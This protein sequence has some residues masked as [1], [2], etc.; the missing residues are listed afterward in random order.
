MATLGAV[1]GVPHYPFHYRQV[2]APSSQWSSETRAMVER[3]EMMREKLAASRP[4]ALVVIGS[5]H[6][7]QFFMDN[8][9]QFLLGKMAHFDGIFYNEIREFGMAP[10]TVPGDEQ[11]AG[12]LL[13]EV[14]RRGADFAF[15]NE[16]KLDHSVITPL[17]FV[18]P[19]FD[20][21]IVPIMT[22]CA[23]QPMP[24]GSRLLQ[25]GRILREAIEALPQRRISVVV[26]GHMSIEVGGTRQ[27][28]P[29]PTD[30]AFDDEVTRLIAA[31]DGEGL[32]DFCTFERMSQAG[33]ATYQFSNF[34]IAMG[35]RGDFPCTHAEALKRA[36]TSQAWYSWE[37]EGV[38]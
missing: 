36:G 27:F 18:R 19:E 38:Q 34:I 26:S 20:L 33:N 12:A 16:L 32:A 35:L 24:P 30:E 13:V 31:G 8:M 22:N 14:L 2:S 4:D 17:Q 25:V 10:V 7:H 15:S 11:L 9:P 37:P 3:G 21:P 1:I 29:G 5:D 28:L 6:A 23:A